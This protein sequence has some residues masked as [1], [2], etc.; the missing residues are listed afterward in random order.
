[1]LQ[2]YL[3]ECLCEKKERKGGRGMGAGLK[4]VKASK[5]TTMP[6]A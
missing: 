6:A 3:N 5:A 2:Q 1:M 4:P